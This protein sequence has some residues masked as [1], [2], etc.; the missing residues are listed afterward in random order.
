M[1]WVDL[2]LDP[3]QQ[4]EN[5]N[6]E[7]NFV[8]FI[9][10][11]EGTTTELTLLTISNPFLFYKGSARD[12]FGLCFLMNTALCGDNVCI[13]IELNNNKKVN[14]ASSVNYIIDF[15]I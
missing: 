3:L 2:F 9:S 6:C 4:D 11:K 14:I 7:L 10:K 8:V 1:E 12:L 13:S 15:S 5:E